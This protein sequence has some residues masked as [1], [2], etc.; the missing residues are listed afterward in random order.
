MYIGRTL[1]YLILLLITNSVQAQKVNNVWTFGYKSGL[2]FNTMPASFVKSKSEVNPPLPGS[3]PNFMTSICDKEGNLKFY[4]DGMK[5]W[6]RDHFLMP[7]YRSWWPWSGRLMPLICP[8]PDPANDSLYYLFGISNGRNAHK[9]QYITIKMHAAGDLEEVVYPRPDNQVSYYK[10]I[11][12]DASLLLAGTVH[13][14]QKDIWIVTHT[15]GTLNSFLVTKNGVSTTPI[16]TAIAASTL[17][18]GKIDGQYSNLKFAANGERIAI[19]VISEG[20]IVILDFDNQSGK[21]Y[22]PTTISITKNYLLEDIELSPDASKLYVGAWYREVIDNVPGAEIHRIFQYDLNAGNAVQIEQT[23]Y[24]LNGFG[25]RV[26]CVRTCYMMK[27]TMQ[28]GPDGK[29][30]ASMRY[31]GGEPVAD[32]KISL[33]D[34]PN[35]LREDADYLRN[36]IQT[37]SIYQI[38]NY[39]YIRSSSFSLYENGI[40]IQKK[41]CSDQPVNFSLLYNRIDSVKWDF[42]DPASGEANYSTALTPQHRYPGPGSYTAKAILYIRCFTD[43]AIKEVIIDTDKS[44]KVPDHIRDTFECV[45]NKLTLDA[46]V[47]NATGYRWDNGLIYSYRTL[48]TPGRYTITVY[49]DCSVDKKAFLFRY[50]VCPC[51]VYTPNAFTPNNDG[52]NDSFR[53]SVKCSAKDYKFRI[54]NR[55]GGIAFESSE[56]NKGWNGKMRNLESPSGVY[57]WSVQ[58]RNP[59]TKELFVKHGT[60]LLIR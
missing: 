14:N 16:T 23:Q 8:Y 37:D 56:V 55:Y 24:P 47:T 7:I 13:C 4:T 33:I 12:E 18:A 39:N 34:N 3:P 9:L 53:P 26:S 6:N 21:F 11:I 25:D 15:P 29:I 10:S 45:G 19:P 32:L 49:N 51:E 42:G 1:I 36:K 38:I 17:P 28:L 27:R 48:D 52:L 40:Q 57:L 59:N 20:K 22:N 58:Y 35:R 41:T 43:T 5:V 44:V 46:Q 30:Y 2:N 60:V 50:D 31:T 54:Y